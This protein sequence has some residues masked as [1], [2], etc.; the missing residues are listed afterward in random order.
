MRQTQR[1]TYIS[2][3]NTPKVA[4]AEIRARH[5]TV[6]SELYSS[7]R[8]GYSIIQYVWLKINNLIAT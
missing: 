3:K 7:K 4:I 6:S 8:S 2:S 5:E 1:T